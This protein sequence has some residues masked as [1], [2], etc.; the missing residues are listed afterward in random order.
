MCVQDYPLNVAKHSQSISTNCISHLLFCKKKI[1][2]KIKDIY[3][4]CIS[5]SLDLFPAKT[6][7]F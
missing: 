4:S 2:I 5:L 3:T 7:S 6:F 1:N